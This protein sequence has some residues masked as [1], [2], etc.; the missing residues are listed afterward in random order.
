M[1]TRVWQLLRESG[2]PQTIFD[3]ILA[4]YEVTAGQLETDLD[5]LFEKLLPAGLVVRGEE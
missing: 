4:E 2:D 3:T 5:A 1:G